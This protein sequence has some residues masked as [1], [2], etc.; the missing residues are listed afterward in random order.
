M[1]GWDDI[2]G[3]FQNLLNEREVAEFLGYHVQTLRNQR[4]AGVGPP[5]IKIN[6]SVR[7]QLDDIQAY[8]SERRVTPGGVR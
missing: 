5:Y 1:P 3:I 4:S 6:R 2:M 7:Y 8:L